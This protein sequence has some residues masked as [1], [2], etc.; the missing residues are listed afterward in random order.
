MDKK[1]QAVLAIDIGGSKIVAGAVCANGVVYGENRVTLNQPLT[2]EHLL[3]IVSDL[4]HETMRQ[5]G[6]DKFTCVG[7]AIPGLTDSEKGLWVYSSFSGIGDFPIRDL[8]EADLGLSVYIDNDVNAC[9]LGEIYFGSCRDVKD[10][11]WI[12]VSNGVGGS[13]VINGAIH[14]GVSGY[15]GELGH[16]NVKE[17]GYLCECGNRGCAE[18]QA[19]GPA[20]LRNYLE[21]T[22]MSVSNLDAKQLAGLASKGDSDAIKVFEE[23]GFF[24]GKAIAAAVNILNTQKVIIGGGVALSFDLFYPQ[25]RK[26]LDSTLFRVA[27]QN[28]IV[29]PTALG[30]AA[31]LYGAAAVGFQS[32]NKGFNI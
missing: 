27:N 25:L 6:K 19:A 9:A 22:G 4:C 23:T 13:V 17:N 5:F 12:T 26:T 8:L 10:F 30:Y 2:K 1:A 7:I 14:E 29:E 24:L 3:K 15:A 11:L 20:I 31:A 18:A 28:L 16:V 32:G 21:R